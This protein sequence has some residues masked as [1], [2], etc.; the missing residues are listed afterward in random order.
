MTTR[1]FLLLLIAILLSGLVAF[2]V[3]VDRAPWPGT[4]IAAPVPPEVGR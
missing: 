3:E 2:T 4:F 1:T